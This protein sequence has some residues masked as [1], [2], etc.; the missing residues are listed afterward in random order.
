MRLSVVIVC[1]HRREN[2]AKVALQ[3]GHVEG[4]LCT[5]VQDGADA[6]RGS[7]EQMARRDLC[8]PDVIVRIQG[9]YK[10]SD[11]ND[12]QSLAS[13]ELEHTWEEPAD[14]FV[15]VEHAIAFK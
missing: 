11:S 13:S 10:E 12:I 8:I 5:H 14:T 6:T 15:D 7:K 4:E 1:L 2:G 3:R 9:T